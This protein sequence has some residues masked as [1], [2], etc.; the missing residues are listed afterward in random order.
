MCLVES[1]NKLG[2]AVHIWHL[3][4]YCFLRSILRMAHMSWVSRSLRPLQVSWWCT[5]FF[6]FFFFLFSPKQ[7]FQDRSCSSKNADQSTAQL[8]RDFRYN[9]D[10]NKLYAYGK[11]GRGP[12]INYI[13]IFSQFLDPPPPLLHTV[14]I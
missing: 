4:N 12:S 8:H 6:F 11:I 5:I 10:N 7:N 13:R 14:R 1:F 9:N 2:V 3:S